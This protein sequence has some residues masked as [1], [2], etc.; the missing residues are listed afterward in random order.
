MKYIVLI[1]QILCCIIWGVLITIGTILV[2]IGLFIKL[3]FVEI[4]RNI[5][6]YKREVILWRN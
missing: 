1:F 5:R 4:K 6:H 2:I 3:D